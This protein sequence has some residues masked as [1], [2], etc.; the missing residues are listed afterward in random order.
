MDKILI[1]CLKF[2]RKRGQFAVAKCTK[3]L[4]IWIDGNINELRKL[5]Y[6]FYIMFV[7]KMSKNV[8]FKNLLF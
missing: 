7:E 4:D 6:L 2:I 8:K 1:I 5:L 3:H